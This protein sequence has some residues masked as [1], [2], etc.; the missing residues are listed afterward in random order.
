MVKGV[1]A[2]LK[3][4]EVYRQYEE[5]SYRKLMDTIKQELVGTKLP[6]GMFHEFAERIYKRK[7]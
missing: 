4:E 7:K 3:L 1:Y 2:D 5:E 6:D